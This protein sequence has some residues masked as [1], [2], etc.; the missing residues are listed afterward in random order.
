MVM[1]RPLN[2]KVGHGIFHCKKTTP[3]VENAEVCVSCP[4]DITS[5]NH[6]FIVNVTHGSSC[7]IKFWE[8]SELPIAHLVP[9]EHL[10]TA[11]AREEEDGCR[12]TDKGA[13]MEVL[14]LAVHA[15]DHRHSLA[16]VTNVAVK[17][18]LEG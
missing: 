15:R 10:D 17:A 13:R 6:N 3:R 4:Q 14:V 11:C 16:F 7:A 9:T 18:A 1:R 8:L 5:C 12:L 2:R